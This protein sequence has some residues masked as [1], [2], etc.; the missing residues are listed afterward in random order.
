M[1]V[2]V[3]PCVADSDGGGGVGVWNG[4][5]PWRRG[6]VLGLITVTSFPNNR[7][8]WEPAGWGDPEPGSFTGSTPSASLSF[9]PID[10][11]L[12]LVLFLDKIEPFFFFFSPDSALARGPSIFSLK[13][14]PLLNTSQ[15]CP[16]L[17]PQI[18]NM[19]SCMVKG[20]WQISL[21]AG[22]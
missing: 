6:S 17:N 1:C 22:S 14:W 13:P 8:S 2:S 3:S 10:F 18:C 15:G 11:Q 19:L 9:P 7:K 4:Y 21:S 12:I 16:H 20:I 5:D